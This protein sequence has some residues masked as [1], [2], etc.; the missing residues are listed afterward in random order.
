MKPIPSFLITTLARADLGRISSELYDLQRQT[1]SGAREQ[2]LKGYGAG[3]SLIVS[4]RTAIANSAA[5]VDAANRLVARLDIQDIALGQAAS[6]AAQ[7]KQDIM[8]A[9]AADDGRFLADQ[10]KIGFDQATDA[11]NT[12]YDGVTLFA[13]ERRAGAVITAQTLGELPSAIQT[14]ALYDESARTPTLDLGF[15]AP[16]TVAET[17]ST[18]S[19]KLYSA[20][21]ELN[22]IV[23]GEPLGQPLTTD[24]RARL[25]AAAQSF[26]LAHRDLVE[27]QGRN[28]D[29]QARVARTVERLT[30][31]SDLL[32]KHLGDTA[33]ADLAEVA[34]KLS[35]AQ[36]QYQ[37]AAKVFSQ[38]KDMSLVNFLD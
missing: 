3:A 26:D 13:G 15:G 6:S 31:E 36:T 24:Q 25:T 1:A 18:F 11:L 34:M 21:R 4:A 38:I 19:R 30:A 12:T 9:L 5:R 37:A 16:V 35:A 29:T 8:T 2:D 22:D 20:M 14:G 17:A 33:D 28:G 7:L 27:A 10:L 23:L 32:S